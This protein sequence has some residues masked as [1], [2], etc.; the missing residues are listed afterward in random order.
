MTVGSPQITILNG[1]QVASTTS[2]TGSGGSVTM[3]T[4][5]TLLL[6]GQVRAAGSSPRRPGCSLAPA[7]SVTV[8]AGQL[9]VQGE[10]QIASTTAGLGNGG[11]VDVTIAGGAGMSGA[12]ANGAASGVTASATPGSAGQAGNVTLTVGGALA[13]S[14]GA[15]VSS[16][17]ANSGSGGT[18]Q[19]TALGGLSLQR[20]WG[21]GSVRRRRRR[22][23]M[24]AR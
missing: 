10:A 20:S 15:Q 16:G 18:V 7:G 22:A 14:D 17:T 21:Q 23:A 9:T 12:A 8:G 6:D 3:T 2:G 24:R 11:N 13:L 19:V 1:A 4:P 5:G